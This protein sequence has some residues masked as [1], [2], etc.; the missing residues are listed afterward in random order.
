MFTNNILPLEL[1]EIILSNIYDNSTYRK[2]RL[3]NREWYNILKTLKNFDFNGIYTSRIEFTPEYIRC[4]LVNE[5]IKYEYKLNRLGNNVYRE[6]ND[7]GMIIKRVN[8][9]L[10]NYI[11]F[12][13][14]ENNVMNTKTFNIKTNSQTSSYTPL[15]PFNPNCS[16]M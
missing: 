12:Y 9:E 5:K 4:I 11:Y 2:C 1:I 16:I 10:P 8:V 6:Y 7:R 14:L 15:Y 3:V 13:T